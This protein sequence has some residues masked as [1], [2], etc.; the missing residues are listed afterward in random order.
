MERDSILYKSRRKLQRVAHKI[1]PNELMSKF[2]YRIVLH[3]KL[4]LRNPKTFNE[5]LQWYKLN[6]FPKT[7]LV[8]TC[9]D[10]YQVRNYVKKK[11]LGK[12]L[13]NLLGSWDD[14]K[15]IIW[16]EL[17]KE[18]V[19]KCNHGCAYNII[20]ADKDS[21]DK[22]KVSKQL[23]RWLKEDFGAFNIEV[24]YSNI[25]PRKIICEEF[26]GDI[27]TDYKFYCFNG[28]P[29]FFYVSYDLIHDRQAQI[30][31]FNI[32]GSKLPLVRDDYK[33]IERVELP[34]FYNE[35]LEVSKTLSSDFPFVRVDFF[36]ANNRFYFA[37]LTFT[38]GAAMMPINPIEF[39]YEWGKLL[40][41][42]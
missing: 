3:K 11:G 5:K 30:G 38:P 22:K 16:E 14:A 27:I 25:N 26:L 7:P 4:D 29:H 37:E 17:P 35:M 39:D 40:N 8:A 9:T 33:N 28:V 10:K 19:L 6:Y 2:Y 23:N 1:F 34:E 21:L 20:C 31:F 12:Y 36:I 15:K 24:H 41:Q 13:T 42:I 18:F 32:D